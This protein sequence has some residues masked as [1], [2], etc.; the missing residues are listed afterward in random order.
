MKIYTQLKT[1][2][3]L[4]AGVLFTTSAK[5]QFD[6]LFVQSKVSHV[7]QYGWINFY[8]DS[9][10]EAQAVPYINTSIQTN[11]A[12]GYFSPNTEFRLKKTWT[13]SLLGHEHRKYDQEHYGYPVLGAV[14][15]E[16]S[17]ENGYAFSL[18]GQVVINL[19]D[20]D[21][22]TIT[23][24]EALD[25]IL[26]Q[27][28]FDTL[29]LAWDDTVVLEAIR[30]DLNDPYADGIPEGRLVW[31]YFN[32]DSLSVFGWISGLNYKLCWEFFI[33]T[34]DDEIS[35][36]YY[37]DAFNGSLAGVSSPSAHG[38]FLPRWPY[39]TNSQTIDTRW[40][41]SVTRHVLYTDND[42]RNIHTKWYHENRDFSNRTEINDNDDSWGNNE[43]T[44][45]TSHWYISNT[46]DYFKSEHQ[47]LGFDNLGTELRVEVSNP[48]KCLKCRI[49]LSQWLYDAYYNYIKIGEFNGGY[50]M[51]LDVLA[52]EYSHA[53]IY[54]NTDLNP[55]GYESGAL[56]EGISDCFGALVEAELDGSINYTIGEDEMYIRE[57]EE[58]LNDGHAKYAGWN[59]TN[60]N[61]DKYAKSG[62]VRHW[63]YLLSEGGDGINNIHVSPIGS[64]KVGK[65]L[66]YVISNNMLSSGSGFSTMSIAT[67]EATKLIY[68]V[69]SWEHI[70]VV[71][72]WKAVNLNPNKDC[73]TI[74]MKEQDPEGNN[75]KVYPNPTGGNVNIASPT[76]G[77]FKVEIINTLGVILKTID[78][79]GTGTSINLEGITPGAYIVRITD[80]NNSIRSYNHV[81]IKNQ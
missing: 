42:D 18:N 17:N 32:P 47:W 21:V 51:S 7:D 36:F 55:N 77:K 8:P 40:L 25:S 33:R 38:S 9:M 24:S 22:P 15:V 10:P 13:D 1:L 43:Q 28:E 12:G 69:C 16:H 66:F 39:N 31:Y 11:N 44:A 59:Q 27:S 4:A 53:F 52:H 41:G 81:I 29:T 46:W 76:H 62:V 19:P 63:F 70:Q 14:I 50:Y 67:T 56:H 5:S 49:D 73:L 26:S 64:E 65:I 54:A 72:A 45:T 30:T 78:F 74:G 48:D 71:E 61:G 2:V 57:L 20:Y 60:W 3:F 6:T 75:L 34:S 37:V 23:E 58:P 68:G 35:A 80:S 79:E